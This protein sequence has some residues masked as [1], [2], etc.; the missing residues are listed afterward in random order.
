MSESKT[1][2]PDTCTCEPFEANFPHHRGGYVRS[3]GCKIHSVSLSQETVEHRA[4][5]DK[6]KAAWLADKIVALGDYAK[7]A[8]MF[9]RRWP[10][11]DAER[12]RAEE[13]MRDRCEQAALAI[14]YHI[15]GDMD[16]KTGILTAIR[17]LP[18]SG[19]QGDGK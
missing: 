1:T 4:M 6:E 15:P 19:E 18:L 2:P 17:S 10:D 5:N 9:L 16:M 8:A 11:I 12:R 13:E 14:D 3:D 7:E